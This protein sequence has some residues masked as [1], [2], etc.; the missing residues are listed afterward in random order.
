MNTMKL[1]EQIAF[2]RKAKGITQEELA[3]VLGVTN[4]SVSKWE[5][6]QCCPDIQLLPE[7]A[8]YFAVSVDK[9]LGYNSVDVSNDFVLQM[10]ASIENL[11]HG[12]D[13]RFALKHAYILHAV[14]IS[15]YMEQNHVGNPGWDTDAVVEHAG[16]GEW[17]VSC[18]ADPQIT[19]YMRR[20]S[21]FFSSNQ[22]LDLST[23]GMRK[24]CNLFHTFSDVKNLKVITATY[25]LTIAAED[26][27]ASISDIAEE[28]GLPE[29]TVSNA[30]ENELCEYLHVNIDAEP[31]L[32]RIEGCYLNMVPLMTMFGDI[33]YNIG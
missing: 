28:C 33:G 32:Y 2:L 26:L 13:Y 29:D 12:E 7:I 22:K 9:L 31:S 1:N 6:G 27:Y 23:A 14:L 5:S 11:P 4:Q 21:V 17:G 8:G 10:K 15:K 19:S 24:I 20:E 25:R 16:K 3:K 30:I 18:I